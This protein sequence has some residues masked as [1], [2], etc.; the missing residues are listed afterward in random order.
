MHKTKKFKEYAVFETSI[1]YIF[2][3]SIIHIVRHYGETMPKVH[4]LEREL[5][6]YCDLFQ[7]Y[8]IALAAQFSWHVEPEWIPDVINFHV[9]KEKFSTYFLNIAQ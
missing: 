1:Y 4:I 5:V 3:S 8:M 9:W 7:F 2:L 6:K